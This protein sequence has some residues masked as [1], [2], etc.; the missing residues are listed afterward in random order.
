M[1][2]GGSASQNLAAKV[3]KELNWELCPL[4]IRKFPDGEK[5]I[6]LKSEIPE[7]V[8]IIQSTGYPQ[9]E[10][11]MELLFLIKTAKELGAKD[12]TVVIPQFGYGRQEERF[13]S[14]EVI[15]AQIISNLIE[16]AGATKVISLT[17]HEESVKDFF[18]IPAVNVSAMPPIAEY[19][20]TITKDPI[21][22]APDK[23]ALGFAEE[24]ATILNCECTYMGKVRLSPEKVETIIADIRCDFPLE[25]ELSNPNIEKSTGEKKTSISAVKNK[26]A[27]I[28]DDII[29]TGG[30]IVNA[31]EILK[32]HGA[33][34][35]DVCCVH[36]VLVGNAVLK[37]SAAGIRNIASTDTL[38]S[39]TSCISV[40]K[41]ISDTL[42]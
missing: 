2:I 21:I 27:V 7:K 41:L 12:I 13:K 9:D 5:Y 16:Y 11:I 23:G 26:E 15:S 1:I 3:A 20:A 17:L 18:N 33:K 19:I 40:A 25:S 42:K 32:E 22:I 34:S 29:S 24:L 14:G 39:D 36:G 28:I 10:N 35:V 6:R 38:I 4:E 37:M 30:T 31:T 8:A